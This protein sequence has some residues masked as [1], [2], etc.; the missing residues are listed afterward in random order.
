MS[1]PD[2]EVLVEEAQPQKKERRGG[3]RPGAGRPSLVRLNKERMAQGLEPIENPAKKKIYKRK[4]S[5]AILPKRVESR[6]REILAEMLSRKSKFIVQKVIDKALDD[7]DDDQMACLKLVMDRI[8]PQEYFTKVKDNK[9]AVQIQ[10]IGVD[11]KVSENEI[12]E[13]EIVEDE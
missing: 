11:A 13:A 4:Q 9:S 6:K 5:D 3:K 7:E 2:I 1:I 12:I 8:L 10:I